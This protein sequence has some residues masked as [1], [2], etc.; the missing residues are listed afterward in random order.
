MSLHT[1]V[2]QCFI[3]VLVPKCFLLNARVLCRCPAIHCQVEHAS[4]NSLSSHEEILLLFYKQTRVTF[5]RG[6]VL[7][8]TLLRFVDRLLFSFSC[9]VFLSS[10]CLQL[11]QE[12]VQ[13]SKRNFFF[14]CFKCEPVSG[15]IHCF[16][17][18]AHTTK[19]RL[20]FLVSRITSVDIVFFLFPGHLAF[21]LF[22]CLFF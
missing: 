15:F 9:I 17:N 4:S 6:N 16:E 8:S 18:T 10:F 7:A 13:C 3:V 12:E 1:I 14:S 20:V 19:H 2:C 22:V 21:V 5:F 11:E